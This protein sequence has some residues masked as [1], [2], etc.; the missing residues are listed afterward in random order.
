MFHIHFF[1]YLFHSTLSSG[2]ND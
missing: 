1:L 2:L